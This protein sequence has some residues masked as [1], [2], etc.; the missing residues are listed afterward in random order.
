MRGL[1]SVL[2]SAQSD[3]SSMLRRRKLGSLVAIEHTAKTLV[4]PNKNACVYGN[5]TLPK[6]NGKTPFK[7]IRLYML[8][9]KQCVPTLPT[10]PIT[11]NTLIIF[12]LASCLG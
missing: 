5:P 9:E 4:R 7:Y 10:R 3:K 12:Y 11:R 8:P 2:A 1:R 6:F